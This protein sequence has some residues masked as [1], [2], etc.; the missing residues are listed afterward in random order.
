M[1]PM[2]S[3][4][5]PVTVPVPGRAMTASSSAPDSATNSL[6]SSGDRASA[7]GFVPKP[8]ARP[9]HMVRATVKDLRFRTTTW[10]DADNA[11]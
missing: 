6:V 4:A 9:T 8:A 10:S 5:E 1:R 2:S 3:Q 7:V 11:T